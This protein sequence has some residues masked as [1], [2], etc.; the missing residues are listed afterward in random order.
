MVVRKVIDGGSCLKITVFW[1]IHDK[2]TDVNR[3]TKWKLPKEYP[4]DNNNSIKN[5][6]NLNQH[7]SIP[8]T[9]VVTCGCR[10][11]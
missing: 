9:K 5:D 2:Y 1:K 7:L 8:V 3:K 10:R 4:P 6:N 11:C